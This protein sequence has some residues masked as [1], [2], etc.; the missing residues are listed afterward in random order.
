MCQPSPAAEASVRTRPGTSFTSVRLLPMNSTRAPAPRPGGFGIGGPG[1][2]AGGGS[3]GGGGG[4]GVGGGV[5]GWVGGSSGGGLPVGGE[6]RSGDELA[7]LRSRS[8]ARDLVIA[9]GRR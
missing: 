1:G 8:I 4:S 7:Q 2:G 9:L 6:I 5:G 3:E